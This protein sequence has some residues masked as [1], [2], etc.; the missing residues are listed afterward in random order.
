[1]RTPRASAD[2]RNA[3]ET[4]H[5]VARV[6]SYTTA[7]IEAGRVMRVERHAGR[8]RRDAARLGLPLP[9]RVE[10]ERLLLATARESFGG[11]DGIVRVEWCSAP[12]EPPVLRAI[13]RPLGDVPERWRARMARTLHPGP[14][15]R[16]N[17]KTVDVAPYD[18][19]REEAL[20]AGVDEVLLFDARGRLV[21]GGHSN[22]LVVT[23]DGRLVSPD[24]ELGPVEGL[25]L[26]IVRESTPE[27]RWARLDRAAVRSAPELMAVNAVRGVVPIVELDDEAVGGGQPGP[28][29][30][31][32]RTLFDP[33]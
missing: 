21:E 9:A 19:A 32:L 23:P 5:G 20:A 3:S 25:G 8:L 29:A 28:W 11:G 33:D 1:M 18:R 31:R 26:A 30:R 12:G 2:S 10:I 6:G 4:G 27:F 22:L 15:D 13:P 17:T 7:R 24:P 16:H 14:E